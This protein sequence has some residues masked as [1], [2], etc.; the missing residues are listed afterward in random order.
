VSNVLGVR[1]LFDDVVLDPVLPRAAD[2]LTFDI[3]LD[4]RPVRFRYDVQGDGF[5]PRAVRVNG[6]HM[7]GDR[8]DENPYRRGGLRIPKATFMGALDDHA[9]NLVDISI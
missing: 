4:G 7:P 1:G 2:G 5:G 8:P 3:E 6:H 9:L